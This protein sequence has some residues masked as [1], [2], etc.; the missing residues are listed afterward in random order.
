[1]PEGDGSHDAEVE[2]FF[3]AP[4][5]DASRICFDVVAKAKRELETAINLMM[6]DDSEAIGHEVE[7]VI[8]RVK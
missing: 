4:S 2:A 8:A 6:F 3:S 5:N 7:T 1:M